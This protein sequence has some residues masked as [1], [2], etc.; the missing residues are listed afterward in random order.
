MAVRGLRQ[1]PVVFQLP[2]RALKTTFDP[3]K[4]VS[5]H[6]QDQAGHPGVKE[7]L[8]CG[9]GKLQNTHKNTNE[10][11]QGRTNLPVHRQLPAKAGSALTTCLNPKVVITQPL[12]DCSITDED[13]V[14]APQPQAKGNLE[15]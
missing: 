14:H 13:F 12:V 15:L 4:S 7:Q 3:Q 1:N 9:E 10:Q 6:R 11:L 2:A 5:F 8:S